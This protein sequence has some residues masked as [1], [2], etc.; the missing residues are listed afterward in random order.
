MN[1]PLKNPNNLLSIRTD[2]EVKRDAN[3][4]TEGLPTWGGYPT[5]YWHTNSI[6][7]G[8]PGQEQAGAGRLPR[9]GTSA[10]GSGCTDPYHPLE[11]KESTLN[12]E[13]GISFGLH[14]NLLDYLGYNTHPEPYLQGLKICI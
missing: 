6:A 13:N 8:S 14:H 11:D 10:A 4:Y 12:G 2:K 9:K 5:S 3:P 1:R 7:T